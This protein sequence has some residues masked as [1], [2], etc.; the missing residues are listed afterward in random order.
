MYPHRFVGTVGHHENSFPIEKMDV[1][2]TGEILASISHDNCVKFW[3]ISYL[4]VTIYCN[5]CLAQFHDFFALFRK[6][7]TTKPRNRSI[8]RRA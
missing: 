3:N 4:E 1:S 6:W 5:S 7:I 2:S 8:K